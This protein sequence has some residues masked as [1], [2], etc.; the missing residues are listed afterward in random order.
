MKAARV[1]AKYPFRRLCQ[2]SC[3]AGVCVAKGVYHVQALRIKI[4]RGQMFLRSEKKPFRAVFTCISPILYNIS[5]IIYHTYFK[6]RA[7]GEKKFDPIHRSLNAIFWQIFACTLRAF[8]SPSCANS[9]KQHEFLVDPLPTC[10]CPSHCPTPP[11]LYN[12]NT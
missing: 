4:F 9:C 12:T 3:A 8:V 5:Y 2:G 6:P 11:Q 10:S 7:R 1:R